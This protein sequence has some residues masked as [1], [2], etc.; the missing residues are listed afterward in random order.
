MEQVNQKSR[1]LYIFGT[2]LIIAGLV[3]YLTNPAKAATALYSGAVFGTLLLTC[4]FL[5]TKNQS[6]AAKAGFGLC[7][8]LSI[9]FSWRASVGWIA[10]YG[11]NND[12]LFAAVLISTMLIGALLTIK[13]LWKKRST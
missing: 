13:A 11:G 9:I 2:Y 4:G 12:K 7:V 8:L 5:L 1:A 6:W 10:V 3:G